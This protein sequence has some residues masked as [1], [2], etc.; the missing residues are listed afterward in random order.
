MHL[1]WINLGGGAFVKLLSSILFKKVQILLL[2][3]VMEAKSAMQMIGPFVALSKI[4]IRRCSTGR[5]THS[6]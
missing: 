1:R 3:K 6:I 2:Q 4:G 5:T